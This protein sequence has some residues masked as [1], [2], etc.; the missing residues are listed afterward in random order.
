MVTD[1][2]SVVI[3]SQSQKILSTPAP[4]CD[5]F[6]MFTCWSQRDTSHITLGH[7]KFILN[8]HVN[9]GTGFFSHVLFIPS[10]GILREVC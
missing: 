2:D 10:T 6:S 5:L 7:Y 3:T 9:V 1:A 8:V 4:T